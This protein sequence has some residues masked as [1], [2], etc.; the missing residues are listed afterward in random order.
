MSEKECKGCLENCNSMIM[1][2]SERKAV[3][4]DLKHSTL[5]ALKFEAI[6]HDNSSLTLKEQQ[7]LKTKV[8]KVSEY[9]VSVSTDFN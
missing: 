2:S 1:K 7:H 8:C 3:I 9:C 6:L 4:D 5:Y